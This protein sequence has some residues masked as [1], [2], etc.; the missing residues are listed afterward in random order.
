M[1]SENNRKSV[2]FAERIPPGESRTLTYAVQ[3]DATVEQVDV[4]IYTGPR[5]DLHVEPFVGVGGATEDGRTDRISLV[6]IVGKD[7]IDG[8]GDRYTFFPVE[9]VNGNND[10]VGVIF[11]NVDP[12]NGY[13]VA[14]DMTLDR[15]GNAERGLLSR[16]AGVFA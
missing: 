11:D 13:D 6:E 2:R 10:T 14:V 7:Y 4:R 9:G 3:Q 1:S 8:D 15:D 5:L 16:L 12:E